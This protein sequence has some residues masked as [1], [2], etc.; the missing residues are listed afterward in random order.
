MI[1]KKTIVHLK[2]D[3]SITLKDNFDFPSLAA[4]VNNDVNRFVRVIDATS[5]ILLLDVRNI[6]SVEHY[7]E[8]LVEKKVGAKVE[9]E[10]REIR[11]KMEEMNPSYSDKINDALNENAEF[12]EKA[13]IKKGSPFKKR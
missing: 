8:E 4:A 9:K 1:I 12:N 3:K 6:D 11:E 10:I 7:E 2:G 13:T 5:S